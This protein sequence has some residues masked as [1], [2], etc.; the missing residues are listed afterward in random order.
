MST[1]V[2][3]VGLRGVGQSTAALALRS[4]QTCVGHAEIG[5][6]LRNLDPSSELSPAAKTKYLVSE[7]RSMAEVC[8]VL[9]VTAGATLRA[10]ENGLLVP[11]K[12]FWEALSPQLV[13]ILVAEEA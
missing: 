6:I 12:F 5:E 13:T 11:P 4:W 10:L 8:D 9:L 1:I 3:V 2:P 7:L